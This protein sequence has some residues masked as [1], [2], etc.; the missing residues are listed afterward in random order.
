MKRAK[1]VLDIER[2][3]LEERRA[4]QRHVENRR[5]EMSVTETAFEKGARQ[6]SMEVAQKSL[7]MGLSHEIIA[8]LTALSLTEIAFLAE[9]KSIDFSSE[10][11]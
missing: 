9:G 5:I 4:Y 6:N 2:M 8:Q 1:T 7:Q 10:D 3:S 11:E